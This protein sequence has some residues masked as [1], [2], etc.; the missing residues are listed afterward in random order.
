MGPIIPPGAQLQAQPGAGCSRL[1]I[2]NWTEVVLFYMTISFSTGGFI[3]VSDYVRM[4]VTL[5]G[6]SWVVVAGDQDGCRL[7][8]YEVLWS[9][10]LP[11]ARGRG[12]VWPGRGRLGPLLPPRDPPGP[13]G[14]LSGGPLV[15]R[16]QTFFARTKL[17]RRENWRASGGP[18]PEREKELQLKSQLRFITLERVKF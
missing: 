13:S 7:H 5:V 14:T 6:A 1:D 2:F 4:E 12:P 16:H 10:E 18:P 9:T 3:L 8:S 17:K 11:C 15:C